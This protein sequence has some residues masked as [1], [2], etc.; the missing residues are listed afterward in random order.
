[1]D[2]KKNLHLP[3]KRFAPS[4]C[5]LSPKINPE[6]EPVWVRLTW[7]KL[8]AWA[9]ILPLP[10]PGF[11]NSRVWWTHCMCMC[12]VMSDSVTPWTVARQAPLSIDFSRQECWNGLP[13][14]SAGNLPDPGIKTV[15]LTSPVLAGRLFTTVPPGKRGQ[16]NS[17]HSFK[18]GPLGIPWW[19]SKIRTQRFH[20]RRLRF[21]PCS[22]N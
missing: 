20:C 10:E 14:P 8:R 7:I 5:L 18:R 16:M 3:P 4:L 15:S 2:E 6:P 17:L 21:N 11:S 12:S 19:F 13:F 9:C 22:G 1:M